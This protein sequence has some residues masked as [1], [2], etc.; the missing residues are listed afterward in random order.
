M[1]SISSRFN[2]RHRIEKVARGKY[3]EK[4][5]YLFTRIR[6]GSQIHRNESNYCDSI[7]MLCIGIWNLK[8]S[9]NI[10]NDSSRLHAMCGFLLSVRSKHYFQQRLRPSPI[11]FELN[12]IMFIVYMSIMFMMICSAFGFLHLFALN[13]QTSS[14]GYFEW[15]R[16]IPADWCGVCSP[17]DCQ[18][19]VLGIGNANIFIDMTSAMR[20]R[21]AI[22]SIDDANMANWRNGAK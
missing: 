17:V 13:M 16:F 20:L 22:A 8:K 9:T 18:Q 4:Y 19:H 3:V 14:A 7:P 1:A 12:E 2:H 11:H 21:F 10:A 6:Q 5:K 15:R